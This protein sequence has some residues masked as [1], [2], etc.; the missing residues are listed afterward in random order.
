MTRA[1][2]TGKYNLSEMLRALSTIGMQKA[3][4][5]SY[6]RR[7]T[8]YG[9]EQRGPG[10]GR[11]RSYSAMGVLSLALMH[12][13]SGLGLTPRTL[14]QATIPEV[15]RKIGEL[16]NSRDADHVWAVRTTD[17]YGVVVK[18]ILSNS[19]DL[20]DFVNGAPILFKR[21]VTQTLET[22]AQELAAILRE[23]SAA[24]AIAEKELVPAGE[25]SP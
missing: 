11:P 20:P 23:R 15:W 17:E 6:I 7:G 5:E 21:D 13:L 16:Q 14:A 3:I 18:V 2:A 12:E 22:V 19:A 8:A 9:I 10:H 25:P 1:V 4:I 24:T